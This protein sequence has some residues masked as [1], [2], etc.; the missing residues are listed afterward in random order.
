M[1]NASIRPVLQL[2]KETISRLDGAFSQPALDKK[3]SE[4]ITI[5]TTIIIGF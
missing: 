1:K 2:K 5:D 4:S 3:K